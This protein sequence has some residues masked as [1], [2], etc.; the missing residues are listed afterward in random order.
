[1]AEPPKLQRARRRSAPLSREPL[2][3]IP[4]ATYDRPE[5]VMTRTLPAIF[6]Q[7]Y[8]RLEVLLIGDGCTSAVAS[9][10]ASVG[11]SRVT[12]KNLRWRSR[13]PDDPVSR[14]MVAG[15]RPRNWGA[16][17]ATG[18]VLF[19]MSDDDLLYPNAISEC[20]EVMLKDDAE[21]V[22]GQSDV[23]VEIEREKTEDPLRAGVPSG[24]VWMAR[25][26]L[27][28]FRWNELS[29]AKFWNRPSDYDLFGRMQSAGVRFSTTRNSVCLVLPVGGTD[30]HGSQAWAS[31]YGTEW[32]PRE[33]MPSSE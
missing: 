14:W 32:A 2:V 31:I 5:V 9:R 16:A 12:F 25:D 21:V 6:A 20:V 23:S 26:Y 24:K 10:L 22:L 15:A 17:N 19:W 33:G 30:L 29:Y 11:D 7:T 8:E 18:Q 1:M 3:S 27:R 13:L 28:A 4:I